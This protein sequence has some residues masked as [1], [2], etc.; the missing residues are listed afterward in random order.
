MVHSWVVQQHAQ[1]CIAAA[2]RGLP[3]DT[4]YLRALRSDR[5]GEEVGADINDL[6]GRGENPR[7]GNNSHC[8][9][10]F[11]ICSIAIVNAGK[12]LHKAVGVS[13]IIYHAIAVLSPTHETNSAMAAVS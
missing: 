8:G 13:T 5:V 1:G 4:G 10:A 9:P 2:C 12:Y 7:I 3:G 6:Q 11:Q